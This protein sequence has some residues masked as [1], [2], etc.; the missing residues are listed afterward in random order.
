MNS[1]HHVVL[2]LLAFGLIGCA[3][4]LG[5]A[6]GRET[7]EAAGGGG[8]AVGGDGSGGMGGDGAAPST[9]GGGEGGAVD[10]C[11]G[12]AELVE[13]HGAFVHLRLDEPGGTLVVSDVEDTVDGDV[14]S[15]VMLGRDGLLSCPSTAAEFPGD[16]D[17]YI[18]FGSVLQFDGTSPFTIELWFQTSQLDGDLVRRLDGNHAMGAQGY[19]LRYFNDRLRF[20]RYLDG[21]TDTVSAASSMAGTNAVH[22]LVV[23]YD[24]DEM[25]MYLEGAHV[26]CDTSNKSLRT[27]DAPFRLGAG[28]YDGVLDEVAIYSRALTSAQVLAHYT[29]GTLPL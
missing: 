10:S 6:P 1:V 4:I 21:G 11:D 13:A 29:T 2:S 23:T 17:D 5:I 3:Q 12:Y 27:V 8:S 18:D 9:G 24:G 16:G 22:H 25:C 14:G 19:V 28:S 26:E 15:D 20:H 7:E